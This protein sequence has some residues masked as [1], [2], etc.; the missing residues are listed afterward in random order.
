[1][2]N[3]VDRFYRDRYLRSGEK[4]EHSRVFLPTLLS[5][6]AASCVLYNRTEHS[7]RLFIRMFRNVTEIVRRFH[8][9]G[10][11]NGP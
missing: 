4:H 6:L 8:G 5:C 9:P 2:R 7:Q 11:I 10:F 1:M 3:V